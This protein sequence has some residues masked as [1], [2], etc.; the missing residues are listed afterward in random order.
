MRVRFPYFVLESVRDEQRL[1]GLHDGL[2]IR[3]RIE[4]ARLARISFGR[5]RDENFDVGRIG[6]H[7]GGRGHVHDL[8]K[9][10]HKLLPF[11]DDFRGHFDRMCHARA[12]ILRLRSDPFSVDTSVHAEQFS[13]LD[14]EGIITAPAAVRDGSHGRP[15]LRCGQTSNVCSG[16]KCEELG[17]TKFFP[18]EVLQAVEGTTD[19]CFG[20][21]A[22]MA[23]FPRDVR[24]APESGH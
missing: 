15:N 23:G 24:F 10:I 5:T 22:D 7:Y 9:E 1:T 16:S 14:G 17:L 8:G 21:K 13:G 3:S 4:S 18:K 6:P 20:S 12:A 2:A 19:V 11:S